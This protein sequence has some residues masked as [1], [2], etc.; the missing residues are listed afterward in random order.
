MFSPNEGS[1]AEIEGLFVEIK[2]LSTVDVKRGSAACLV[3]LG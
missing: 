1:L 2:G 3:V